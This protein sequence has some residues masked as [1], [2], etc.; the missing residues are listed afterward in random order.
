MEK[1]SVLSIIVFVAVAVG[2][3]WYGSQYTQYNGKISDKSA[4]AQQKTG[5][6]AEQNQSKPMDNLQI[7]DI[8]VGS[9]AEAKKGN[10]VTVNYVGTLDNGNKFHNSY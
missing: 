7:K 1:S 3:L 2:L 6:V 5:V 9:G 10:T 8:I 4:E